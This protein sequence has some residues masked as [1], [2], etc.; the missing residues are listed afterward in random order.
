M[1][2]SLAEEIQLF[3]AIIRHITRHELG[4][5][6]KQWF[7]MEKRIQHRRLAPLGIE[8]NQAA[9]A[10]FCKMN[11]EERESISSAIIQQKMGAN[12]KAI[13]AHKK[14]RRDHRSQTKALYKR[15]RIA[16]GVP[17][18]WKRRIAYGSQKEGEGGDNESKDDRKEDERK[19]YTTRLLACTRCG[20]QQETRWMQLR[21]KDG[22]RAVHCPACHKQERPQRSRCQCGH[23]WHQCTVHRVDPV[24][25]RSR[26]A[27]K[28]TEDERKASSREVEGKAKRARTRARLK[29]PPPKVEDDEPIR[30]RR[31][32]RPKTGKSGRRAFTLKLARGA[33]SSYPPREEM[34]QRLRARVHD[35]K[36]GES[37]IGK[38]RG[39]GKG[40]VDQ[41]SSGGYHIAEPRQSSIDQQ[42]VKDRMDKDEACRKR[43][44]KIDELTLDP[45]QPKR[46]CST[47]PRDQLIENLK[48]Q[49]RTI[50][51]KGA[52]SPT[53]TNASHVGIQKINDG[54][55]PSRGMGCDRSI[56]K[57]P[58]A[59]RNR[60]G[61]DEDACILRLLPKHGS[62][63]PQV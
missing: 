56:A 8:G 38:K 43:K 61:K 5:W 53:N 31:G 12:P 2:P 25:H 60:W 52:G 7:A 21:T 51:S 39:E 50:K 28:K 14:V 18:R 36:T 15:T 3:K 49:A 9:M 10:C 30:S 40:K 62:N 19:A 45:E 58:L 24:V 35:E 4:E 63:R 37:I 44:R 1:K 32:T 55:C 54:Q 46:Q 42:E 22:Y 17:A 29:R 16:M 23:I 34:V 41:N 11:D 13:K 33:S 26:R 20:H 27:P 59:C 47:S 57:D 6:Q 48:R